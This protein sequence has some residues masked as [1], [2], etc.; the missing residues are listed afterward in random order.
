[1]QQKKHLKL[2]K[3]RGRYGGGTPVVGVAEAGMD[4]S[5]LVHTGFREGIPSY[6]KAGDFP[7]QGNIENGF[8]GKIERD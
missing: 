4:K 3:A 5:R 6:R 7:L 2:K 1:V 8:Q